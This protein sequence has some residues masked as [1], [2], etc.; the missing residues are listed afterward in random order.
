MYP[1]FGGRRGRGGGRGRGRGGFGGDMMG[2]GIEDE[3]MQVCEWIEATKPGYL[4]HMI[5]EGGPLSDDPDEG[6]IYD[7]L[8]HGVR[9]GKIT[10]PNQGG[11]GMLGG[12]RRGG[13]MGPGRMF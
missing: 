5:L 13:M 9:T 10:L 6:V 3:L 7:F 1:G 4:H 11:G 8:E 12:G 2:G